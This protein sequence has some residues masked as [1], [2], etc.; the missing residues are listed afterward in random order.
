M[1]PRACDGWTTVCPLWLLGDSFATAPRS[2]ARAVEFL[3]LE[4][5]NV[6]A[7]QAAHVEHH[8][9]PAAGPFAVGVGLDAARL[10]EW[11]MDR[12]LVEPVVGHFIFARQ[13]LEVIATADSNGPALRQREQ[14]HVITSPM[15]A[16]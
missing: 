1:D 7:V 3:H 15:S 6:D 4:L 2:Q 14:L 13:Q 16:C 5:L 9:V 11:M 10:A 8:H 12:A